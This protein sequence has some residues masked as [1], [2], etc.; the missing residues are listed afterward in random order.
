LTFWLT[1]DFFEF[2]VMMEQRYLLSRTS[3]REL[4]VEATI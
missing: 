4:S 1:V 3:T 2:V